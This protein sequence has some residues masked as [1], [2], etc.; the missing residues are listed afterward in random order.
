[1]IKVLLMGL[2][3]SLLSGCWFHA[4]NH[5]VG[6]GVGTVAAPAPHNV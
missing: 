4:G 2:A 3:V 1:M 5:G 6:G